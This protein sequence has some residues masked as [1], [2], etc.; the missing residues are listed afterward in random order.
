MTRLGRGRVQQGHPTLTETPG[1][2]SGRARQQKIL[3]YVNHYFGT[4]SAFVGRSTGGDAQTRRKIVQAVIARLRALP[5]ELDICVC[6][7]PEAALVAIDVDL[8]DIGDPRLIVYESIERMFAAIND[9]DWFLNIEDDIFVQDNLVPNARA[10]AAISE[11]NEVWLPNRMES[12]ADGTLLC[13]D[14]EAMPGWT[15]VER[16]FQGET[17]GVAHNHHS[18]LFLLSREQMR[19]ASTRVPLNRREEFHGGLMASAYANIHAPFLLWRA[20]SAPLAHYVIHADNWLFSADARAAK[21]S[22]PE[23]RE[24]APAAARDA[25]PEAGLRSEIASKDAEL[26]AE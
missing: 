11:I 10:F 13:V 17:L 19:Y 2:R 12:R 26:S 18:G 5:G 16:Q 22:E 6:G 15:G 3:C 4:S 25:D 7:F 20:K 1:K 14:L 9:Y 21:Q 8:S 23:S 24:E